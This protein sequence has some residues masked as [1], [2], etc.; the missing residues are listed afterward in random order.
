MT[1][2]NELEYSAMLK[3][4]QMVSA[5]I[6]MLQNSATALC[7][8]ESQISATVLFF[9]FSTWPSQNPDL[10]AKPPRV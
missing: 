8:S 4:W 9:F 3:G 2:I 5:K 1:L 6:G 7:M 10:F